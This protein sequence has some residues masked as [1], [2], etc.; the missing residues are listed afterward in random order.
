MRYELYKMKDC[1]LENCKKL[2]QKYWT[3]FEVDD[4]AAVLANRNSPNANPESIP[5]S[6]GSLHLSAAEDIIWCARVCRGGCT[7]CAARTAFRNSRYT[8]VPFLQKSSSLPRECKE[9]NTRFDTNTH[10]KHKKGD[11]CV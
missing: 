7:L 6:L 2:T 11:I 5:L 10:L 4:I 1:S 8:S 9:L 3:I